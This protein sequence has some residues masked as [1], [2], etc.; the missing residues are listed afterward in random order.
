[1]IFDD[2]MHVATTYL[3]EGKWELAWPTVEK[4]AQGNGGYQKY[5]DKF[6]KAQDAAKMA[7]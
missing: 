3:R 6:R 2:E 4:W 5:N 1:M 7:R